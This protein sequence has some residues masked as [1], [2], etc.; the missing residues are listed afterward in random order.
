MCD[1]TV[2]TGSEAFLVS[3]A[4]AK[5]KQTICGLTDS[6]HYAGGI[7]FSPQLQLRSS[8]NTTAAASAAAYCRRG[9]RTGL[10][11]LIMCSVLIVCL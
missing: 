10:S 6:P 1:F 7:Q 11:T 2:R 3:T 5:R 9:E 8:I 4:Q